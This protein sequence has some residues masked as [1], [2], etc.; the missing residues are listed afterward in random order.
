MSDAAH[1]VLAALNARDIDAF[2]ACYTPTATI[3]NGY[4]EVRVRGHAELRAVYGRFF[5]QSP[6]LRV[7]AGWRTEVGAFVVQEET[8]TGRPGHER[9]VAVYLLQEDRIARERLIA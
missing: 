9:H 8:V 6:D 4:D 3:E 7:E 1:R 2:V 5:E